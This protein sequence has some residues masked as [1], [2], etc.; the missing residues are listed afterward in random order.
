[1]DLEAASS[2]GGRQLQILVGRLMGRDS[3]LLESH[4]EREPESK[5]ERERELVGADSS[6]QFTVAGREVWELGVCV[7]VTPECQAGRWET[8]HRGCLSRGQGWE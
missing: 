7:G 6:W 3:R 8:G 5:A 2:L 4:G 1:M